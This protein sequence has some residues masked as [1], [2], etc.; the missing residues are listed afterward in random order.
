MKDDDC[1]YKFFTWSRFHQSVPE[2]VHS[3][4]EPFYSVPELVHSVPEPFS[5]VPELIRSVPEPVYSAPEPVCSVPE[6]FY[7]VPERE[8]RIRTNSHI[9]LKVTTE[10][11]HECAFTRDTCIQT[12]DTDQLLIHETHYAALFLIKVRTYSENVQ[13]LLRIKIVLVQL[14]NNQRRTS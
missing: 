8:E 7:F 2:P 13:R 10:K 14:K 9:L 12:I 4:P 6:P 3:V 1:S 11:R 5:S